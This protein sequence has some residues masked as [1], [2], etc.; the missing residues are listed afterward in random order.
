V[1][2]L[3]FDGSALAR[4]WLNDYAPELIAAEQGRHPGLERVVELLGPGAS[5]SVVPIPADCQDGFA[6]AFYARPERLLDPAVRRAQSSWA[7][8]APGVE[9]R[10]ERALG[11]DLA[12][13]RWDAL[14]GA[15]RT[16]PQYE[17]S[18]RL[19]TAS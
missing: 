19:I 12:S 10:F 15:W 14:Y 5:V 3:A 17:G 18:L 6:E 1:V 8:V 9:Q 2:V 13:G 16:L 11:D 4:W 7:F